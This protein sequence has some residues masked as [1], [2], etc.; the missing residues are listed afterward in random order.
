MSVLSVDLRNDIVLFFIILNVLK[1]SNL[2]LLRGP[3]GLLVPD[4]FFKGLYL[5]D[6]LTLLLNDVLDSVDIRRPL[7]LG[8]HEFD[9]VF[10]ESSALHFKFS[11]NLNG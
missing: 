8:N 7:S 11:F 2:T 3:F 5:I 10:V 9:S 4:G 1:E 6:H